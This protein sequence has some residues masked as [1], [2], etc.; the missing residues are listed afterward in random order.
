MIRLIVR[1]LIWADVD[2]IRQV[3][4]LLD[5]EI[6]EKANAPLVRMLELAGK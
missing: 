2:K 5:D 1:W 4:V 3:E 6:R